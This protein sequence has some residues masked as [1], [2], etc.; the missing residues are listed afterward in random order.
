MW[1]EIPASQLNKDWREANPEEEA[2]GI[3][4]FI[5]DKPLQI[6]AATYKLEAHL[7][8]VIDVPIVY[9]DKKK[10]GISIEYNPIEFQ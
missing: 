7:S 3:D 1:H 6:K 5:G 8:E 2:K 10:D 4:G 9:Y